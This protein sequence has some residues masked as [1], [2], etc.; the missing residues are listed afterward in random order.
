[1]RSRVLSVVDGMSDAAIACLPWADLV[2]NDYWWIEGIG[3]K[4]IRSVLYGHS[5]SDGEALVEVS[6]GGIICFFARPGVLTRRDRVMLL[7]LGA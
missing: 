1:M 5:L 3:I 6:S 2:V 7:R 4:K